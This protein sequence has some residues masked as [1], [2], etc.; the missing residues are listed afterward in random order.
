MKV[1]LFNGS[2]HKEGSTFTAL[3]QIV[4][5][6]EKGGVEAEIVQ[7]GDKDIRGCI[8]C[9][10]CR[11]TGKCIF[12]DEVNVALEKIKTADG[13]VF[14]S[15][16]Y[17]ASANGTMISFLDRLFYAG[18]KNFAYKPGVSVAVA[19]RGGATATYD[20]L[21]KYI[22]ISKMVMVPSQYWNMAYGIDA[23]ETAADE[24][25]MQ[26]MR[27]IGKNMVWLLKVLDNAKKNGIEN[28]IV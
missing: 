26:I 2:P 16:V 25:G 5:E 21:N 11:E 27:T 20:M 24:E 19:R 9:K 4:N 10:K 14:A 8:A 7:I 13:F 6:L 17:Y 18:S 12:D 28:P 22:G 1:I 3:S 15:P 23:K